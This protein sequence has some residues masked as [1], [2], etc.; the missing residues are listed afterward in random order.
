MSSEKHFTSVLERERQIL[1][2]DN[3]LRRLTTENEELR[4]KNK[5]KKD[6]I[7]E[8]ETEIE[9]I[10]KG[11]KNSLG[12]ISLGIVASNA[13]ENL[14]KS[15]F[16][17]GLL[18]GIGMKQEA[19]NGLLG[20]DIRETIENKT[21]EEHSTATIITKPKTESP[22]KDKNTSN[23]TKEEKARQFVLKHINDTMISADDT[24]LRLYYELVVM[25]GKN[26]LKLQQVYVAVK[27]NEEQIKTSQTT[28]TTQ[29]NEA[30][31]NKT[32]SEDEGDIKNE[33]PNNNP[34]LNDS[35]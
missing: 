29:K 15:E 19:I 4:K 30:Q 33:N 1:N 21:P 16:G 32:D 13:F 8:L 24:I 2:L 7:L 28:A 9:K 5:K 20:I 12:N 35:S 6:Y 23:L 10:E 3:D 27:H 11:K 22:T 31:K 26:L 34:D 18:K 25:L 14:A 17:L